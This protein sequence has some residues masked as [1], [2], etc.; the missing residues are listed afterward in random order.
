M[1]FYLLFAASFLFLAQSGLAQTEHDRESAEVMRAFEAGFESIE[2]FETV[3]NF[4]LPN[5]EDEK[6][7]QVPW[8]PG[9]WEGIETAKQNG[10][11]MFIWA[12]NGDPLG[13]V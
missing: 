12:M 13:C 7:R 9:L 10:K 1:R 3:Y 5:D 8:L 2:D 11:P 4:V 6:W